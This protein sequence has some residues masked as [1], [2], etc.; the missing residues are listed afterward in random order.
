M[1]GETLDGTSDE[2]FSVGT[3]IPLVS[4]GVG[5]RWW[6]GVDEVVVVSENLD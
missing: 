5:R 4:S 1:L 2:L 3:P 6:G